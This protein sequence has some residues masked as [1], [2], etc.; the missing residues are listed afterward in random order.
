MDWSPWRVIQCIWIGWLISWMLAARWSS[1]TQKQASGGRSRA[2]YLPLA[3]GAFLL[4]GEPLDFSPAG[5]RW[6]PP[7]W[8]AD[9]M[10]VLTVLGIGFAWWARIHL[11]KL[12]SSAVTL[13]A[14][15]RIVDTG[16]YGIVRHPIYT[17][18]LLAIVASAAVRATAVA[19]LGAAI[20]IL[21][22]YF[23]ARV[24]EQFLREQLGAEAYEAYA[25]RVPMLLPFGL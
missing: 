12:W 11:G 25:R 2:H 1:R 15:H 6:H 4:F 17:G 5:L 3:I 19:L 16:P 23:K 8:A 22:L 7:P 10:V 21:G 9:A 20:V 18:I 24:E 14:D 13:K